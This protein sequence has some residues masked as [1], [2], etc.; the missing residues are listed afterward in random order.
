M[1]KRLFLC[2]MLITLYLLIVTICLA[3]DALACPLRQVRASGG[4]NV[5]EAP[6]IESK[7]VYLLEDTENV[8]VLEERD[9]WAL[10]AKG[11]TQ[12]MILGWVSE[13][14]LR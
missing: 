7:A 6:G 10:V 9:G 1:S 2:K 4:L 8:F 14:Y 13:D 5:R 3:A 12:E 11:I